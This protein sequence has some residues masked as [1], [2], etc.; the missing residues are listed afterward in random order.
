MTSI[1]ARE[2]SEHIAERLL[3]CHK[4]MLNNREACAYLGIT[5]SALEALRRNKEITYYKPTNKCIYYK[6]KDL[7]A[8]MM[9]GEVMSHECIT[10]LAQDWCQRNKIRL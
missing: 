6:R 2:M 8:W 5:E 3:I 1:E 10:T 9:R 4:D 7:D